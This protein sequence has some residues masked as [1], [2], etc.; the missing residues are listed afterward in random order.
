MNIEMHSVGIH[1]FRGMLGNPKQ[2]LKS[3]VDNFELT[4]L[5]NKQKP[6]SGLHVF[7]EQILRI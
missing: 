1:T 2:N 7:P 3:I 5:M 6:R 4:L